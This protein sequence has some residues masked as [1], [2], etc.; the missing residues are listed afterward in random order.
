MSVRAAVFEGF[1][2]GVESTPGTPVAGSTKLRSFKCLMKEMSN[3]QKYP[4]QGALFDSATVLGEEWSE[5]DFTGWAGYTEDVYFLDSIFGLVSPTTVS[6][7]AKQRIW[8][9]GTGPQSPMALT[10]EQGQASRAAQYAFGFCNSIKYTGNRKQVQKSGKIIARAM[11][12]GFTLTASP[13]VIALV[14]MLPKQGSIKLVS[15][16]GNYSTLAGA[17]PTRRGFEWSFEYNSAYGTL[18]PVVNDQASFDDIVQL[19]PTTQFTLQA[20]RNSAIMALLNTYR[21]ADIV[22]FDVNYTGSAIGSSPPT[23]YIFDLQIACEIMKA[24]DFSETD[25]VAMG[26]WTFMPVVAPDAPA[27]QLTVTNLMATP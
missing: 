11:N 21:N 8:T 18:F 7:T 25:G 1:Q 16:S 24:P 9:P 17:T 5:G 6:T 20:E 22:Y 15:G 14:P 3:D 26:L 19:A 23:N 13:G 4:S 12:D 27:I 10:I 2:V